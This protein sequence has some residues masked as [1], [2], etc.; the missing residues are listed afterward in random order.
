[1]NGARADRLGLARTFGGVFFAFIL[2][3]V[4]ILALHYYTDYRAERARREASESLNV[5]LAR[6]VL[7]ALAR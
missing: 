5:E 7:R 2:F 3:L 6:R 4:A 1:M